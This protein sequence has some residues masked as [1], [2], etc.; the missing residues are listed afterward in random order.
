[1]DDLF[2]PV[3]SRYSRADA[4]ADGSQIDVTD[5]AAEAGIRFPVSITQ[6]A[7]AYVEVPKG[8]RGQDEKGRLWDVV[9]MLYVAI[10]RDPERSEIVYP[11][12]F[13]IDNRHRRETVMLKALVGPGDEGDPVITIMLHHED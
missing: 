6:A 10:R 7:W 8:V 3:I 12:S 11:V 2:G 9:F 4:I 1:M 13:V 5:T